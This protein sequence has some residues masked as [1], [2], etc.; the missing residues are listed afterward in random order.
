MTT[1]APHSQSVMR[2]TQAVIGIV[3]LASAAATYFVHIA[4]VAIPAFMACGLILAALRGNCP[5]ASVIAKLPWNRGASCDCAGQA[6][7]P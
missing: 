3:I 4:F 2:Q 5:M 1:A 7:N 6:C